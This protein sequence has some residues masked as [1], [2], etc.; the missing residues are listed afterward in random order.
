MP[1]NV[2]RVI[3]KRNIS[4]NFD[5]ISLVSTAVAQMARVHW[6]RSTD[7]ID[8]EISTVPYL[9]VYGP[10][11]AASCPGKTDLSGDPAFRYCGMSTA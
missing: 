5:I 10:M 11:T 6:R 8:E 9:D 2:A 4:P 7:V 1:Y 3:Y